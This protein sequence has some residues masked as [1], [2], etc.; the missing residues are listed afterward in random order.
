MGDAK[1]KRKIKLA[2]PSGLSVGLCLGLGSFFCWFWSVM[3]NPNIPEHQGVENPGHALYWSI[4]LASA[5]FS[6]FAVLVLSKK[7]PAGKRR[8]AEGRITAALLA[9][10]AAVSYVPKLSGMETLGS[11]YAQIVTVGLLAAWLFVQWGSI[12]GDLGPRRLLTLSSL[13]LVVSFAIAAVL[14]Q[15]ETS[16]ATTLLSLLP[17]V[18]VG[19][20]FACQVSGWDIDAAENEVT[21]AL[22]RSGAWHFY[23]TVLVQGMAFGL[24]HL[25]YSTIVLEQCDDPYCPL[26]F[27]NTFF[28]LVSVEDFYGLMSIFGVAL[29]AGIVL[30]GT[31]VLRLNFRKLIYVVGF[32]LMAVGF[33]ILASDTGFRLTEVVSHASGVNFTAGEVVY[34]AGYYYVVVTTWALC[35]YLVRM[36]KGDRVTVF[37]R[38]GLA[39]ISG[40]LLGFLSSMVV[41]FEQ[42]SR[43]DFCTMAIFLLMLASLLIA[44]NDRLWSDW[45]GVRPNETDRP[46]AFKVACEAVAR[47]YRLTERERDVFVL[48]AR[49]RNM[50]Y[51]AEKLCV[52]KDT[53]KTH[54][55]SMYRKLDVHSQQELIDKVEAEIGVDKDQKL[56]DGHGGHPIAGHRC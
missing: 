30:L 37:A 42:L 3:Q 48:L 8:L 24:L 7:I 1:R 52:T 39:L 2:K 17:F 56:F 11:E 32:P 51:V 44:T 18:S 5:A 35:S 6:F 46:S 10:Y 4:V 9:V 36:K 41:G 25:L 49:G 13:S 54:C 34:I 16:M 40:Q 20:V 31:S 19:A 43:A 45:G 53:V 23:V 14:Y 55:R 22:G 21:T 26:R 47:R 28:P 33:L 27:L 29:A 38:S 50:S 12:V 15:F